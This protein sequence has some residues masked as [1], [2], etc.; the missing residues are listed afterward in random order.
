MLKIN[1]Y[2]DSNRKDLLEAVAE[3]KEIWKNEGGK[4]VETIEKIS[5]LDFKT[6][7]INAIVVDEISR[8]HPLILRSSYPR[9]VKRGV[10]IH[11]LCH[12]TIA[13]HKSK[14]KAENLS[15]RIYKVHKRLYLILYDIWVNLYGKDFAE[16]MIKRDTKLKPEY[17]KAWDWALSFSK[18]ERK[19]R[20]AEMD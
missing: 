20:F 4:I 12:R 15:N 19:Q 8:S 5:G 1:F 14:I 10:L 18:E 9:K 2:P 3:Y 16:Q 17:E 7:E 6:Q 13:R 11:E